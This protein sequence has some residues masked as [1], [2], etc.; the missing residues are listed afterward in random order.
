MVS[1]LQIGPIVL[2]PANQIQI[3]PITNIVLHT[4]IYIC[5]RLVI[6]IY[7][8][9]HRHTYVHTAARIK[10]ARDKFIYERHR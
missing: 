1:L 7:I 3:L 6:Y 8:Y 5:I 4:H 2:L 10:A 9:P